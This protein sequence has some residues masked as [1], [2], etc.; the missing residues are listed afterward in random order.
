MICC[1]T[2]TPYDQSDGRTPQPLTTPGSKFAPTKLLDPNDTLLTLPQVSMLPV[3]VGL[4]AFTFCRLQST[5]K[6]PLLSV[7]LRVTF[8]L[9]N[10]AAAPPGMRS[11]GFAFASRLPTLAP[12]RY[13]PALTLSAVLPVPKTSYAA[14]TRGVMSLY[15]VTPGVFGKL[16]PGKKV[17]A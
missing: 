9:P 12:C 16:T 11:D 14:P 17:L 4:C 5:M 7:Q 13:L 1:C 15:P 2:E 10:A 8:G 3:V 6:L